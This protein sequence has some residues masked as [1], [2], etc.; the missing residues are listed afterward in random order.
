VGIPRING[1]RAGLSRL[2]SVAAFRFATAF[3]LAED[4]PLPILPDAAAF[5][6]F[7]PSTRCRTAW[8]HSGQLYARSPRRAWFRDSARSGPVSPGCPA[9]HA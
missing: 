1:S 2:S 5:W 6:L 8:F 9:N 7:H 4:A 3:T